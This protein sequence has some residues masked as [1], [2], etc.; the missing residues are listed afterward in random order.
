M[1]D[2]TPHTIYLKDY[3][4]SAFLIPTIDLDVAIFEDYTRVRSRL[5]MRRNSA[6]GDAQAPLVLDGEELTLE[7]VVLDGRVLGKSAYV[8]DSGHLTIPAVPDEFVLEISSRIR[9]Q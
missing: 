7:S 9:P 6:V 8:V 2:S 4:P 1:P 3:K 5:A